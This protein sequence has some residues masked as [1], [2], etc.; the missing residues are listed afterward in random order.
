MAASLLAVTLPGCAAHRTPGSEAPASFVVAPGQAFDVRLESNPSTGYRWELRA[1]SDERVV[2]LVGSDFQRD[3][4][5]AEPGVVGQVGVE[6]WRFAATGLGRAT[7]ELVYLRPWEEH[8]APARTA[9]YSV[10]VR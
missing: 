6:T 2:R 1:P 10:E 7:I 9:I 5:G 8:V 3:A 4:P